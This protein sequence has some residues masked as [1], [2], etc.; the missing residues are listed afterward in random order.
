MAKNFAIALLLSS[1]C[2]GQTTHI[3]AHIPDHPQH[4]SA[5]PMGTEQSLLGGPSTT[6]A[7]GERPLWEV[8]KPVPDTSLGTFAKEYR[9]KHA[10]EPKATIIY[11][12][13]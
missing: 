5:G 7:T 11:E 6:S 10:T 13:Q 1:L 4:A 9:E 3:D 12:N 8:Y 2:W